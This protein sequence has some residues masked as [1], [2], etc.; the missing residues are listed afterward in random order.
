M[1]PIRIA[2]LT[3]HP[4]QYQAPLFRRLAR[5]PGIELKVFFCSDY[6]VR[7]FFDPNFA[8]HMEWDVPLL[9]GYDSE[10]L[11]ARSDWQH[12]PTFLQPANTWRKPVPSP[13]SPATSG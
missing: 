11:P 12:A 6:S 2:F 8:V 10:V 9:D 1:P 5:E 13:P 4:I 3:T 7:P